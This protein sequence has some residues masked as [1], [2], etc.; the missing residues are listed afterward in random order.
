MSAK[1]LAHDS[2]VL[3]SHLAFGEEHALEGIEKSKEGLSSVLLLPFL[4]LDKQ[5]TLRKASAV[6]VRAMH[7]KRLSVNGQGLTG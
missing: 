6:D 2:D 3:S 7:E 4:P 5:F 1:D